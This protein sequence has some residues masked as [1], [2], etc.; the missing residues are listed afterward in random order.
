[1]SYTDRQILKNRQQGQAQ[2]YGAVDPNTAVAQMHSY[3]VNFSKSADDASASTTTAET[4]TGKVVKYKS[5]LKSVEYRATTGGIT[6]SDTLFIT[7]T[8]SVRDS[9]GANAVT[10][11][12]LTTK[13]TAGG[14]SGDVTQGAATPLVLSLAN[15]VIPAGS[16][17]TY[18]VAKASTGTIL[19][20]GEFVLELEAIGPGIGGT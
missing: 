1:M 18:T 8:V 7:V 6:S 16:T 2:T 9:T 11:A 5:L 15:V 4:Y 3:L 10:V 13:T 14:G 19:R 17:V 20:A 12:T